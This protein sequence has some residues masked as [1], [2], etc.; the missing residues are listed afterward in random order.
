MTCSAY[1]TVHDR[2]VGAPR[3][4]REFRRQGQRIAEIRFLVSDATQQM[5]LKPAVKDVH[6]CI[7]ESDLFKKL[8]SHGIGERLA[9]AWILQDE[10]RARSTVEYVEGKARK[11]QVKGSTAGYIHT[12]FEGGADVGESVF[13]VELKAQARISEESK[14]R[15][16]AEKRRKANADREVMECAKEAVLALSHWPAWLWQPSTGK[17]MGQGGHRRRTT[18]KR[19]SVMPWSESSSAPGCKNG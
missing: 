10:V 2:D 3:N 5:A 14:K 18:R 9:I 1:R 8:R 12:L 11:S 17:G 6:S 19:I 16:E 4:P 7:R 13:E 15:V